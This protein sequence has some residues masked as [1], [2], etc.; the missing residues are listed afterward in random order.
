MRMTVT[1]KS[2]QTVVQP[3][4]PDADPAE[5]PWLDEVIAR[6]G[7]P[8]VYVVP[9]RLLGTRSTIRECWVWFPEGKN[10]NLALDQHPR[11]WIVKAN[12]EWGN[13]ASAEARIDGTAPPPASAIRSVLVAAMFLEG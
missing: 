7:E 4:F 8:S 11:Y 3:V 10:W 6:F 9:T 13:K 1:T 5:R 2:I 12:A